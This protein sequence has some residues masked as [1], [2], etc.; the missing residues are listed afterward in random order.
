MPSQLFQKKLKRKESFLIFYGPRLPCYY[1]QKKTL[2]ENCRPVS[3]MNT[4]AE[5][6]NK[7]GNWI[8][9]KGLYAMTKWIYFWNA[10]MIQYE[11]WSVQHTKLT[12]WKTKNN[13]ILSSDEKHI[14]W[15]NTLSWNKQKK[16]QANTNMCSFPSDSILLVPEELS[17][18]LR[19]NLYITYCIQVYRIM[20]QYLHI[21]QNDCSDKSR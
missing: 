13:I 20:I 10:R 19:Y 1:S 6:F 17:F 11:N 4:D 3:P 2:Q 14:T 15:F 12:K 21:Q 5:I 8:T 16:P 9:L 18:R 7:I